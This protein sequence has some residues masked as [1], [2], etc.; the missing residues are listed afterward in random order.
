M[1]AEIREDQIEPTVRLL[2]RRQT[3]TRCATAGAEG[4]PMISGLRMLC[5]YKH[6]NNK[7]FVALNSLNTND[8]II[9]SF[10]FSTAT[11][12]SGGANV[13]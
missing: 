1:I 2:W 8:V 12:G 3:H 5:P 10:S 13:F 11:S 4:R 9:S 6:W 7:L